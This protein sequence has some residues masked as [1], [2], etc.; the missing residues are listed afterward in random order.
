MPCLPPLTASLIFFILCIHIAEVGQIT[1]VEALM[2]SSNRSR[3]LILHRAGSV[4]EILRGH[5]NGETVGSLKPLGQTL[6]L[7]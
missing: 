1:P 2:Q 5:C 7:G 4:L 6:N 3:G